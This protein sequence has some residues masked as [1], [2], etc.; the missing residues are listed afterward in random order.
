MQVVGGPDSEPL[1]DLTTLPPE[2]TLDRFGSGGHCESDGSLPQ[3]RLG[4]TMASRR[5][6]GRVPAAQG[7][8][9]VLS[10]EPRPCGPCLAPD[11]L[12][13]LAQHGLAGCAGG[14]H[15]GGPFPRPWLAGP[16]SFTLRVNEARLAN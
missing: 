1:S 9:V 14:D 4:A 8:A 16:V 11:G 3:T 13:S 10:I 6:I 15:D 7:Q 2:A 12:P 5:R